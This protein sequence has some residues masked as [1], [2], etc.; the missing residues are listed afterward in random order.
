M[1]SGSPYTRAVDVWS[2][3]II[4]YVMITGKFPFE[5][6]NIRKLS[7]AVMT[8]EPNYPLEIPKNIIA[9]IKGMLAK[10]PKKRLTIDTILGCSYIKKFLHS[11]PLKTDRSTKLLSEDDRSAIVQDLTTE[12]PLSLSSLSANISNSSPRFSLL[13]TT[14]PKAITTKL[15]QSGKFKPKD[16]AATP[17]PMKAG[18][19]RK[20]SLVPSSGDKLSQDW[21]PI[22]NRV[23][24]KKKKSIM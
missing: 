20:Q 11:H 5:G 21:S 1:Y 19:R 12:E 16:A 13:G 2:L 4:L 3:G 22:K 7:K 24:R 10:D 15:C 6:E 14:D 9:L 23:L 17:S 8:K 18:H